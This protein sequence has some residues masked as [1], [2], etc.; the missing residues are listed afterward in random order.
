MPKEA[1]V[2]GGDTGTFEMVTLVVSIIALI[3]TIG[4][5]AL[6]SEPESV[7][8]RQEFPVLGFTGPAAA[9]DDTLPVSIVSTTAT[10]VSPSCARRDTTRPAGGRGIE[11]G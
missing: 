5:A 2:T 11:N 3:A 4:I 10:A 7:T 8:L 9:A 6:R 1:D